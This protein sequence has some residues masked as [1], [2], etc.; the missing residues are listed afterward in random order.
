VAS[1]RKS[2]KEFQLEEN[3]G[4]YIDKS[5]NHNFNY[6][7]GDSEE[8]L[9]YSIISNSPDKSTASD[10]LRK[11]KSNWA[12]EYHCSPLRHNLLRHV[13]FPKSSTLLELGSGCGAITRQLGEM[14]LEV[15]AIEGSLRRAVITRTRCNDQKNVKVYAA[16]FS[17]VNIPGK[18]DYVTLVGVLEYSRQFIKEADPI[19][20][21]LQNSLSLL[22]SDGVLVIAIENQLGLKYLSG[23]SE[24]HSSIK[25]QGIED[26][27]TENSPVTFGE[28]ELR[29]RLIAAGF[30]SVVFHYPYPD[31]KIPKFILTDKGLQDPDFIPAE[32]IRQLKIRDY[33]DPDAATTFQN[34]FVAPVLGRNGLLGSLA[35]SFLVFASRSDSNI[36]SLFNPSLLG[37]FYAQDRAVPYWTSTKFVREGSKISVKKN[38]LVADALEPAEKILI[39][40]MEDQAYKV[41]M[42]FA[43]EL[44][45]A[46]KI[47]DFDKVSHYLTLL[48]KFL[49]ENAP[50]EA[51]NSNKALTKIKPDWF[52]AIPSNLIFRGE[53]LSIVD[54]EWLI[55]SEMNL[56]ELVLRIVDELIQID[57]SLP[58]LNKDNL[59]GMLEGAG[60]NF[61]PELLK[62]YN[63]QVEAVTRQVKDSEYIKG[64]LSALISETEIQENGK[65]RKASSLVFP[66][67][68]DSAAPTPASIQ[69]AEQ[70]AYGDEFKNFICPNPFLYGEVRSDG[71]LATCCYL[72]FTFGNIKKEGLKGA[73]NSATAQAVRRSILDG[74]YSF[75]DKKKCASM[76]QVSKPYK[77]STHDYQVAYQVFP[78]EALEQPKLKKLFENTLQLQSEGPKIVS[79]EDDASCNLACPSCRISPI[80]AS[81]EDSESMYQLEKTV[82]DDLGPSLEEAWF[83]G[84]GDP[85]VSRSYRRLYKEYDFEKFPNL[86]LRLDSNGVALTPKT[87]NEL[88]SKVKH[89]VGLICFSVD[90]A[91]KDTYDITRVG[92]NFD[93]LMKNM[94]FISELEERKSGVKLLM[95]M[96]V[97]RKNFREMKAF[98]ELGRKLNFDYVVFSCLQN[99]GTFSQEDYKK[100]AVHIPGSPYLGELRE[101]L[102]DPIF[103]DPRVNLG[104]LSDIYEE[105]N[106]ERL[107]VQVN[108][109]SNQIRTQKPAVR[110]VAFYLPQFHPIPEND[111]WWGK[112][113]TEWTNVTK[114]VPLYEGHYQP[115]L[116][117]DLGYYDLRLSETR[118][119]QA[120]LAKQNGIEA[121]CYWHYWFGGRRVLERP[122]EEVV[123]SKKPDFGFCFGWANAS[124]TGIW[125]GAANRVLIEQT[126]PGLEDYKNHFYAML[127]A[128]RDERYFRVNDKALI[129]I[130]AP[131]ELPNAKQFTDYWRELA[132]KENIG[133]LHFVAHMTS[134]PLQFGCDTAV[135]NAPFTKIP[136]P[137]L[138]VKALPGKEA[139][140]V[141]KYSDFVEHMRTKP[142]GMLE[143]P[144]VFPN[145]DN[146]PRSGARGIVLHDSTP[147]LYFEHLTDAVKKAAKF[148]SA[149][150]K[151]VFIKAWNEWAEGNYVEPSI[152]HGHGLLEATKA[153]LY[154]QS[155]GKVK[156]EVIQVN[157][158]VFPPNEINTG[159][160]LNLV[161]TAIDELCIKP[162]SASAFQVL[163]NNSDC[164]SAA[165]EGAPEAKVKRLQEILNFYTQGAQ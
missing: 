17:E 30:N 18:Y 87:W 138:P 158:T 45:K 144:L 34:D 103:D 64:E 25:Y 160:R 56:G 140:R 155:F 74:T 19:Q 134:E 149:D 40:K 96:I 36:K 58:D 150:E 146:T 127:P 14:G 99:W 24:D 89:K 4:I 68:P 11:E 131:H 108:D 110:A 73:W 95:R 105:V 77:E 20:Q 88:L 161:K 109:T 63:R 117:S 3:F 154:G 28:K 12:S 139:P 81:K 147:E 135:D 100:E 53:K 124:W 157:D 59:L 85:F 106:E 33:S 125:H 31:Y 23:I 145:W 83:C 41:G 115:N 76:Q 133:E 32:I 22:N 113:F 43:A 137:Q 5:S 165:L 98:I 39:H 48:F 102:R 21:A 92:G 38:K 75:C 67:L 44:A 162:D 15:T 42:N 13:N 152:R 10:T 112:G 118:E 159:S 119:E 37:A 35:N 94:Q 136:A 141:W 143:H 93:L 57:P 51:M 49:E 126:Y 122:W 97:Q 130:Y 46:V 111:E 84:A 69:N 54:Q 114:A 129:L 128:L 120:A 70:F 29:Q 8:E 27:Y 72:P 142:L 1:D 123:K 16:N 60:Y 62:S 7:D 80:M 116:P 47:R 6:S 104:N 101:I 9:I 66:I 132:H 78:K 164:I 107:S 90:A 71:E 50:S 86:K 82:L 79:F 151:I 153:A 55:A 121:F 26:L 156:T 91:T 2:L 61:T 148:S 163:I 52:D 65:K